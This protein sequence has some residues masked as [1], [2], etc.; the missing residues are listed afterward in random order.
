MKKLAWWQRLKSSSND[1]IEKSNK[2]INECIK[3]SHINYN[4]SF[5]MKS[6]YLK[7]YFYYR[8][9]LPKMFTRFGLPYE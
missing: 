8:N 6:N 2:N 3:T 5:R 4:L 9:L 7:I 1:N